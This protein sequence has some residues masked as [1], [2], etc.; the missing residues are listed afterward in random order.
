MIMAYQQEKFASDKRLT[1]DL[2]DKVHGHYESG[3]NA[4]NFLDASCRKLH[5]PNHA[6]PSEHPSLFQ[7]QSLSSLAFSLR[8]ILYCWRM[9]WIGYVPHERRAVSSSMPFNSKYVLFSKFETMLPL[10]LCFLL[11]KIE[12]V[13][14]FFS[15]IFPKKFWSNLIHPVS[16]IWFGL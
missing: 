16:R 12:E 6:L 4:A 14:F 13:P 15:R 9:F 11:L 5:K 1:R 7:I 2:S 3:S 8:H 10:L